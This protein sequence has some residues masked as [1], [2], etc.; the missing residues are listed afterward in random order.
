[1][2]KLKNRSVPTLCA[3][4]LGRLPAV[5]STRLRL[6]CTV[7]EGLAQVF[8]RNEMQ[9]ARRKVHFRIEAFLCVA[10]PVTFKCS[11][12]PS[13]PESLLPAQDAIAV[14]QNHEPIR[15]RMLVAVD[16]RKPLV[17]RLAVIENHPERGT[18][19]GQ[20]MNTVAVIDGLRPI[21]E[22]KARFS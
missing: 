20:R 17:D 6:R 12:L 11:G 16:L 21:R 18:I 7:T 5:S 15:Q 13:L 1:M 22:M 19:G 10:W 8:V 9:P 2:I 4:K 14:S 3:D